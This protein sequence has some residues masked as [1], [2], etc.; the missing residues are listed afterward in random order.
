MRKKKQ[1][2]QSSVQAAA[3]VSMT[4]KVK[5]ILVG[6]AYVTEKY[7]ELMKEEV[8][9]QNQIQNIGDCFGTV[10]DSLD[11]LNGIVEGSREAME[12]TAREAERFQDVKSHIFDSVDSVRDE[13]NTLKNNSDQVILNFQQMNEGFQELADSVEDIKRC[14]RS[15]IKIANQTNLLSLNASIEAARAGE[16]GKGFSVV[17]QE[18]RSLSEQIKVLITDVDKSV[19]HV[20]QGT[21]KLSGSIQSSQEALNETYRQVEATFQLIGEVQES[22]AGMDGV[23]TDV[24]Q[25]VEQSRDEVH[26]IEDFVSDSREAYDRVADCISDIKHHEN[27]KGVVYE[28]MSNILE[29]IAPVTNS[30]AQ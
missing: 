3:P 26:R 21:E 23:C 25:S 9:I 30:I 17:A 7:Q 13:L 20:E 24:Y 6:T 5:P 1:E 2:E 16:A 14:M 10:M 4:E 11:S 28:D 22:A 29:Q 15:I 18:V 8:E 27:L 19:G 12:N